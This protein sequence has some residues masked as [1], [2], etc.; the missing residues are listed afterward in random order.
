MTHVE[1]PLGQGSKLMSMN[2]TNPCQAHCVA[3]PWQTTHKL[4]I[5]MTYLSHNL[6]TFGA[7]RSSP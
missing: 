3:R 6:K 2:G 5:Y 7:A 4:A 1:A